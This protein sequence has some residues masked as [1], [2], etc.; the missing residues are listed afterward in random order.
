MVC[1][2]PGRAQQHGGVRIVTAQVCHARN[3]EANASARFLLNGQC[4]HVG[5]QQ[6]AAPSAGHV[7]IAQHARPPHAAP[8]SE[9]S[10]SSSSATIPAV[11]VS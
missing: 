5:P 7:Q 11:R 6:H 1:Q 8:D 3:L 10:R 4:V 9:A 2:Q